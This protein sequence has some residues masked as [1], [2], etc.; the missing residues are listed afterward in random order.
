MQEY[1][2]F[3]GRHTLLFVALAAIVILII[4]TELKRAT[5]GYKEVPPSEAVMLINKQDAFVLDIREANELG[6]G[7]IIGAKHIA[8]SSLP[9]KVSNLSTDK[10]K[11]IVVFC[12]LGNRTAQACKLLLKNN[13]TNVFS[14][15]GGFTAWVNDQLPIAKK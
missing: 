9:E 7:S 4:I 2:E 12:K 6:Q 13:Y 5:K 10:D 11:P 8:L 3:A 14:L 1:I 15:K